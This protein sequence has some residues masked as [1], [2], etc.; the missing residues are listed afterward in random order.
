MNQQFQT[1]HLLEKL[2]EFD[3]LRNTLTDL[4]ADKDAAEML[5][6]AVA[7][8]Q[9]KPSKAVEIVKSTTG[10]SED[11]GAAAVG[12]GGST[13]GGGVT[14]GATFTPGAGEQYAGK[15]AFKKKVK[16]D[17]PRLAAGKADIHTYTQDGFTKAEG[18]P[19]GLTWVEPKDLWDTLPTAMSEDDYDEYDDDAA[20]SDDMVKLSESRNYSQFKREASTR[21]KPQQ[22]HEAAKMINKK[23]EEIN[24]LLEFTSQMRM[25]LAEGEDQLEY[26]HNTKKLFEKINTKVVE[27]YAKIKKL[28]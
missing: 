25:E 15:K 10:L 12:G 1:I 6:K 23:L 26:K 18:H 13:T 28:K 27:T 24:R 22:M 8:G 17:A 7:K 9:I 16:E 5:I 2:D 11:G 3:T 4:G 20:D 21:T 19:K 14:N